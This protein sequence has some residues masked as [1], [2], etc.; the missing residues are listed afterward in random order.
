MQEYQDVQVEQVLLTN[1]LNH[2]DWICKTK[3]VNNLFRRAGKKYREVGQNIYSK[4]AY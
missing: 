3:T 4:L 1:V 2:C